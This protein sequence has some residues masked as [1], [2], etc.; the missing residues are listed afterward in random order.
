L[1]IGTFE[2]PKVPKEATSVEIHASD[3]ALILSGIDLSAKRRKRY[4]RPAPADAK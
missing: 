3:L 2:I 4:S 1:E